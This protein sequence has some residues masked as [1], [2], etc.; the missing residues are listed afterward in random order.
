VE[1]VEQVSGRLDHHATFF[2]DREPAAVGERDG[3][4]GVTGDT[5][6]GDRDRA[7]EVRAEP[8][9]RTPALALTA[10]GPRR[11]DLIAWAS[12]RADV[13]SRLRLLA[14]AGIGA[15][16]AEHV[17]LVTEPLK[18]G[19][20]GPAATAGLAA[21]GGI[22]AMIA[23]S[24]PIELR[25]G[26]TTTRSLTRLA[27]FW[28]IPIAG[29]R[30]TADLL[31]TTVLAA[32]ASTVDPSEAPPA[33]L[34]EHVVAPSRGAVQLWTVRA[35][36]DDVPGRLAILAASL[37]RRAINILAVQVHL[38]PD[39]PVDELLVA[40]SP[41]LSAADL[42]AAVVDGGA[43]T[44]RVSP[45]DAHALVDAPTRALTLAAR[46]VSTPD[47]L[48][49]VLASLLPGAQLV[50]RAEAPAGHEDNLTQLWLADPSG[51]GFLLTR[52]SAPFTPAECARAF[53][54]VE[55]A[56]TALVRRAPAP[57]EPAGW[58]VLLADG[59]EIAVRPAGVDDLA[60]VADLHARC[61]LTSRLRRYLAGTRSPSEATL[62]KLLSPEAGHALV[63]EDAEGR[64]IAVGNLVWVVDGAELA[65][66]VE[67]SWQQ[68][69]I[70][71]V[72]ARQL[73]AAA[74]EAG[75]SRIRATVHTG[76]TAVIKIMSGVAHRLHREYDEG[77][78]TLIA[79]VVPPDHLQRSPSHNRLAHS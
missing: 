76:N 69:R 37:A 78:L 45:A 41:V 29:N 55:V 39:G 3:A 8:T 30:A 40:A 32:G 36:V 48:A 25:P 11:A 15:L 79:T 6:R 2:G 24:D 1:H 13:L 10:E 34:V 50:W 64:V 65:L 4:P 52:S 61:S 31:L 72:L 71:T 22:D 43:R 63:A 18:S 74:L 53:A 16:L 77:M 47:D 44:P 68:R 73:V 49:A 12:A 60:A 51:G 23:F 7:D 70:G 35:T 54:M 62:R 42:T 66:L 9:G 75:V 33:D 27:L 57:A 21:T 56:V 46:L 28:D 5:A 67:D 58:R 38:T 17:G 26:D 14:P 19:T 59:T 20:V